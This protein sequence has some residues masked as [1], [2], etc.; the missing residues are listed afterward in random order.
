MG[1]SELADTDHLDERFVKF[2]SV[3]PIRTRY[4]DEGA[5]AP[6][7]LLSGGQPGIFYSLDHWSL[8]LKALARDFR[9]IALDKLG[10]GHTD[11]PGQD[12][13]YTFDAVVEH[14]IGFLDLLGVRQ[15]H[16]VGHSRGGLLACLIAHERP[17]LVRSL[18]I[19]DSAS[20]ADYDTADDSAPYRQLGLLR[21]MD[22]D[23]EPSLETV[24]IEPLGQSGN[25]RNVSP[26]FLLRLLEIARLPKTAAALRKMAELA[27]RFWTPSVD[28]AR[29]RNYDE[30]KARSLAAPVAVFWGNNDRTASLQNGLRLYS[31]IAECT[32]QA[33]MHVLNRAGHC[34]FRDQ[35]ETFNA[36]AS[37]FFA[38]AA[39]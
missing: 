31:L 19:V 27:D 2:A 37:G 8:N 28:A 9:V 20:T 33:E 39:G 14:A 11:N 16:L 6:V 26:D 17:D 1:E 15:A 34:S 35:P 4:Y 23:V 24:A 22:P 25:P 29:R 12:S 18:S 13:Q 36:L 30:L 5:G 7:V 32:A 38:R 10:Q 3:G 21:G